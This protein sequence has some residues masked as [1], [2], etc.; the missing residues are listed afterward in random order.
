MDR[1]M[2]WNIVIIAAVIIAAFFVLKRL[3]F[4][5]AEVAR[6]QLTAGALVIDVRSP[7]EFR[8][9]KVPGAINLP[10]DELREHLPRRVKDKNQ[11]L[12][13]HCLS[14]G[15][16]AIAKHRLKN[17]GYANVFNLGSLGRAKHLYA[18]AKQ[19]RAA[20]ESK[21]REGQA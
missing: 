7:D 9:S 1:K 14:G 8:S 12:L 10:L 11:P 20:A 3:A 19:R 13:V 2:N 16:S 6:K 5:S 18:E 15:R 17:M 4:V 21:S